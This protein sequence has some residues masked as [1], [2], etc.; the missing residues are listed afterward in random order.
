MYLF[1]LV[2]AG[3]MPRSGIARSYDNSIFRFLR[4]LNTVLHSGFNNLHPQQQCRGIPFLSHSRQHLLCVDFFF[5]DGRYDRYEV[6]PLCSLD[7][8]FSNN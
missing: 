6:I 4:N 2:L 7:L 8:H 1:E 5:N 3:Y